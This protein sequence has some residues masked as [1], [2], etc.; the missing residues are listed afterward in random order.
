MYLDFSQMLQYVCKMHKVINL[1]EL[2][3]FG[4]EKESLKNDF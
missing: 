4:N 3:S 2:N 1:V